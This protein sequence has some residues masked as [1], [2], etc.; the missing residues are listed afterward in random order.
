MARVSDIEIKMQLRPC[1]A[2]GEKALF[3]RWEHFATPVAAGITVGSHPAGQVSH[4]NG[5]VE[6]ENGKIK[7]VS[8]EKII[9]MDN[10]VNEYC[11]ERGE[12]NDQ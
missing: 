2:S 1:K 9:F 4:L 11:F 8:P 5:I 12:E 10:Q 7:R 3:H 6:L